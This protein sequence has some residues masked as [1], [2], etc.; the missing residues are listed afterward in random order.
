MNRKK[1]MSEARPTA[2]P[3]GLDRKKRMI[4]GPPLAEAPLMTPA[5]SPTP[6]VWGGV[7]AFFGRNPQ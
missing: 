6:V 2:A 4:G 1:A 7:G 3:S 5:R